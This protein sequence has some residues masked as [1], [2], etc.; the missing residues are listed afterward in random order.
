MRSGALVGLGIPV[1]YDAIV[2]VDTKPTVIAASS[3]DLHNRD[4]V[5]P[6]PC[7]YDDVGRDHF[8]VDH[9]P[10]KCGRY[11]VDRIERVRLYLDDPLPEVGRLLSVPGR[12]R[13]GGVRPLACLVDVLV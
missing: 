5:L 4:V 9:R 13:L 1:P 8:D 2:Q 6:E 10:G 3:V 11:P 12:V 7:I